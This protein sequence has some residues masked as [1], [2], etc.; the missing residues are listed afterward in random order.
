MAM[1]E[2]EKL[3]RELAR[4]RERIAKEQAKKVEA[5]SAEAEQFR[6]AQLKKELAREEAR[7]NELQA[8]PLADQLAALQKQNAAEKDNEGEP[9]APAQSADSNGGN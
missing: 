5:H 4:V 6:V 1:S 2:S 9:A 7:L 3:E 8:A